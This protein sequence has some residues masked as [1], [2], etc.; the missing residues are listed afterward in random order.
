MTDTLKLKDAAEFALD[1]LHDLRGYV[2]FAFDEGEQGAEAI[3]SL[4]DALKPHPILDLPMADNDAGAKT[5]REYLTHLLLTL[6]QKKDGFNGKRPYGNG[7]WEFDLYRALTTAGLMHEDD[8]R[9]GDKLIAKAILSM[10]S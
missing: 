1:V 7:G 4:R 6:W 8:H 2:D 3:I 10:G 5:I 9:T